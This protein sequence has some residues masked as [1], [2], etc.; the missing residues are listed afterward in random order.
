MQIMNQELDTR[1]MKLHMRNQILRYYISY[2]KLETRKQNSIQD[3]AM[4]SGVKTKKYIKEIRTRDNNIITS[5][6]ANMLLDTRVSS[7]SVMS[8]CLSLSSFLSLRFSFLFLSLTLCFPAYQCV[9]S[10]S[11]LVRV[12]RGGGSCQY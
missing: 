4:C 12:G 1:Y 6:I 7:N 3:R 5:K 9:S 8:V 11:Q 2:K 10:S